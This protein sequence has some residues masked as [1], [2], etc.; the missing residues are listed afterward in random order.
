MTKIFGVGLS[1]T[2]T[3]SLAQALDNIGFNVIHYATNKETLFSTKGGGS[4]DI[5]TAAHYKELDKKFPNSKF[6][7]TVRDKDNW[8]TSMEKYLKHKQGRILGQWQTQNRIAIYGQVEFD[9]KVFS[10][11]YDE[12]DRDVRTYFKGRDDLLILNI[13]GG[14][15]L[16]K[17][18]NFLEVTNDKTSK[19]PHENKRK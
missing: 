1:R 9:K 17:L 10:S 15:A 5:P 18:I 16:T 7:Y 6:V 11:K 14:D 19:F 8:L 12:H 13:C 3:T 4:C 2:G